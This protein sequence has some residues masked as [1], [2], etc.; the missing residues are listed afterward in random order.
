M[1]SLVCTKNNDMINTFIFQIFQGKIYVHK[2][3][4]HTLINRKF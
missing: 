1:H 3:N 4:N 2:L